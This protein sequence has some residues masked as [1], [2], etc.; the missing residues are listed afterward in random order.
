MQPEKLFDIGELDV[1][2]PEMDLEHHE[3]TQL[4]EKVGSVCVCLRSQNQEC[5]CDECPEGRAR[6]CFESLVEIGHAIMVKMLDHF[7]HEQDL[8]KSLPINQ[9][10]RGHCVAHRHEHVN[11]ST[12]YNQLVTSFKSDCPIEG[13][14]ALDTFT[15]DWVRHHVL[16]YDLK[17][18]AL[19]K[20]ESSRS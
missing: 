5:I 2:N 17:L 12:R 1:G 11:F 16:E 14:R 7:H 9:S 15:I 19:L 8:M 10:T 18:A 20:A 4:I 13:I 6:T 3:L